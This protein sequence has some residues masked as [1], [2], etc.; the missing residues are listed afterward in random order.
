VLDQHIT[1]GQGRFR[2]IRLAA[3]RDPNPEALMLPGP[4]PEGLYR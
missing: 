4:A 3:A 1:L 2:G